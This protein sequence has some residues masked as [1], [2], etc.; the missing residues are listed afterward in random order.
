MELSQELLIYEDVRNILADHGYEIIDKIGQGS[1]SGCYKVI[2]LQYKMLFVAKV[3]IV[4]SMS[5]GADEARIKA[6]QSAFDAETSH[7]G[8]L[9]HPNIIKIYDFFCEQN[10]LIDI[11]DY[12][13]GGSVDDITKPNKKLPQHELL[14][15][16]RQCLNAL[17]YC[18]E[19]GIAH[20]DIKPGNI[21]IDKYH[22]Y[23]LADFGLAILDNE[24][25]LDPKKRKGTPLFMAPEIYNRRCTDLFKADVWAFGVTLYK[26]ATGYYPFY[27]MN[28]Q[29]LE[30]C[31]VKGVYKQPEDLDPVIAEIIKNCLIPDPEKRI[32]CQNLLILLNSIPVQCK[33]ATIP[34]NK[35]F[36]LSFGVG[37]CGLSAQ[38]NPSSMRLKISPHP[39]RILAQSSMKLLPLKA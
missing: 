38:K 15:F 26:V 24:Y 13:E 10:Y 16:C 5:N 12:C 9:I 6:F 30:A 7:L 21:L 3:T 33:A 19:L 29:D 32:S 8:I 35:P 36:G 34:L 17:N 4:P 11:L 1:Y 18:H 37:S 2:S 23:K 25:T 39:S 27:G 22:R 28:L 20:R 14:V 31:I